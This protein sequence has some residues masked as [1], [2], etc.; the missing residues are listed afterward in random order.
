MLQILLTIDLSYVCDYTCVCDGY[1]FQTRLK[2]VT[3]G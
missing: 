3:I 2:F 1:L